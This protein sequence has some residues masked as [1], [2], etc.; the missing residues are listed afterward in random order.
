MLSLQAVDAITD[1]VKDVGIMSQDV[2]MLSADEKDGI[3][4]EIV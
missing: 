4:Y 2:D 3:E 1:V